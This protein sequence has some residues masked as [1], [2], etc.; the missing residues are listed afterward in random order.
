MLSSGKHIG[1]TSTHLKDMYQRYLRDIS[2]AQKG[3]VTN[4]GSTTHLNSMN[5]QAV[6]IRACSVDDLSYL[7][8]EN[9]S[10][11]H[12][13]MVFKLQGLNKYPSFI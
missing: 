5:S 10:L 3:A 8:P 1:E 6:P 4:R 11:F 13:I 2:A 9:Q 12:Q 7:A